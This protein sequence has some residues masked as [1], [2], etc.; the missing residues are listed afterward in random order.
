MTRASDLAK[1]AEVLD[2]SSFMF[3]NRIINGNMAIDQRN[4]GAT[5]NLTASNIYSLDR[6]AVAT[7]TTPSG[8]LTVQRVATGIVNTPFAARL[9]RT[10]GTYTG[11][12]SISQVIETKNC[13]D[14][15][16]R[17]V[18]VS[19][20][21][22]KGSAYSKSDSSINVYV[23]TGTSADQGI[24]GAT[25]GTWTGYAQPGSYNPVITTN[26]QTYSFTTL[27]E[28]SVQEIAVLFYAGGFTG[29]GSANDYVDITNVQLEAG[30]VA[31]PF[32][33]RSFGTEVQLC[34]RYFC[35]S[36]SLDVVPI[37]GADYTN[38]GMF[39]SS[40]AFAYATTAAYV[41]FIK[42]PVTMRIVPATLTYYNTS[43]PSPSTA[44][45]WSIFSPSGGVWYNCGVSVQSVTQEGWGPALSGSW[46]SSGG[47]PLYG[48]WIAIAEL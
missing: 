8:T 32:E 34:Q 16:G 7:G 39:F 11:S 26:F 30:S 29:S 22:R 9:A 44:G 23:R 37:N 41:G 6:W 17:Y 18:T 38:P 25:A 42:F 27:I 10:S 36:S 24:N 13:F 14:L 19:F 20:Q 48:A 1:T 47:L 35:K 5:Q 2:T 31:T 21:A 12:L 15:A 40:G 45:Q 3:R 28:T 33:F 43:L 4:G 46:G